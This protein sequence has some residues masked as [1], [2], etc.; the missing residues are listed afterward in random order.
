MSLDGRQLAAVS[1]RHCKAPG[2]NRK[3]CPAEI[4]VRQYFSEE[5]FNVSLRH[6]H[7]LQLLRRVGT[8]EIDSRRRESSF[9]RAADSKKRNRFVL[10]A[11]VITDVV[12]E[13][14]RELADRRT[15]CG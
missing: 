9:G 4:L 1:R 2:A 10:T 7:L 11:V 14:S 13:E 6:R 5:Y 3:E 12:P 15:P 8:S